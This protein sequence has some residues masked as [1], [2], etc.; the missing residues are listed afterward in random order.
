ML[1]E[2][3]VR[4]LAMQYHSVSDLAG[5]TVPNK[6]PAV[7]EKPQVIVYRILWHV[8]RVAKLGERESGI[9]RDKLGHAQ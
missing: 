9:L 8:E 3:E 4:L 5:V 1:Q 7:S 6:M 2:R